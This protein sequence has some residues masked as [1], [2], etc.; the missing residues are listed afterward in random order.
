MHR[1][2]A[3]EL[4][5]PEAAPSLLHTCNNLEVGGCKELREARRPALLTYNCIITQKTELTSVQDPHQNGSR[6]DVHRL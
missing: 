6:E 4:S 3:N 2:T 5:V 1:G